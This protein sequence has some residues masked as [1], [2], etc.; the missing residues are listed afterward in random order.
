[1]REGAD[2]SGGGDR[3]RSSSLPAELLATLI[4]AHGEWERT[5]DAAQ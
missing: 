1:M 3:R 4:A 2:G 5:M